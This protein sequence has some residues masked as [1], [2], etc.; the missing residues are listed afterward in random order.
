VPI[1]HAT[2]MRAAMDKAGVKN[3]LVVYTAEMHGFNRQDHIVDF[4]TRAEKF[5]AENL[6]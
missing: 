4:M 2:D 3:E 1:K 6:K 5:F